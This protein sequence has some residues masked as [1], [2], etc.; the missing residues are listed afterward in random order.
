MA[1]FQDADYRC[2]RG[3]PIDGGAVVTCVR[4]QNAS[5]HAAARMDGGVMPF[6]PP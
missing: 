1:H 5:Q 3:R 2:F 4:T 6:G